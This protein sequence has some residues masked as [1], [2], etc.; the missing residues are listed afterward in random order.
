MALGIW[1]QCLVCLLPTQTPAPM[2]PGG[3]R[4]HRQGGAEWD[5]AGTGPSRAGGGGGEAVGWTP[6]RKHTREWPGHS[7]PP[8][9][10]I[11]WGAHSPGRSRE[12]GGTPAPHTHSSVCRGGGRN[13]PVDLTLLL[14]IIISFT[15]FPIIRVQLINQTWWGVLLFAE[16]ALWIRK[17]NRGWGWEIGLVCKQ[18]NQTR[19]PGRGP[20]MSCRGGRK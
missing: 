11:S 20:W 13:K 16:A 3:G 2:I 14:C 7:H 5:R 18:E 8:T 17:K 9:P 1:P 19:V 15:G 6:F 4:Q 10:S 12:K